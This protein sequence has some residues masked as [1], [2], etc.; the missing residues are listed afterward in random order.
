[1]EVFKSLVESSVQD[2]VKF[3]CEDFSISIDEA[4]NKVYNSIT[5]EK[6]KNKKTGMYAES[7]E[8]IYELLKDEINNN[9]F[10]QSE[11]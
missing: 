1:M 6:L 5:Y 2:M 3:L 9:R 7:S 8:Y 4:L 11:I 10:A